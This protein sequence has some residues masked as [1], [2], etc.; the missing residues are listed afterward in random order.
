MRLVAGTR[1]LTDG[2]ANL[3]DPQ[4]LE[5]SI[6]GALSVAAGAF[7]LAGLWTPA[8]GSCAALLG[9]WC[10]YARLGDPW[11]GVLLATIAFAL[12]LIGPGAWSVD[13]RLFGRKRIDVRNL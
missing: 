11:A 4:A 13:A 1:L 3:Q 2:I 6:T 12:V 8:A 5:L 10:A 7:L 9:L